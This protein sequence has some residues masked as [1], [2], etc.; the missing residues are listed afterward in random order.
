MLNKFLKSHL[1]FSFKNYLYSFRS[2]LEPLGVMVM[3]QG[4]IW[5]PW[6]H[7]GNFWV[8]SGKGKYIGI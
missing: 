2:I 3:F 6:G 7:T 5:V 4:N 1:F 8:P